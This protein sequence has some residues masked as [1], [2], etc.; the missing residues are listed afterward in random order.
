MTTIK[1]RLR[2]ALAEAGYPNAAIG[3][4]DDDPDVLLGTDE[5]GAVPDRVVWRAQRLAHGDSRPCWPC[6]QTGDGT[7]CDHGGDDA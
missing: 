6:W 1:E 3:G 2:M 7:H 4:P 5:P